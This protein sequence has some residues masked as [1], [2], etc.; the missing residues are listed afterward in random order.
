MLPERHFP[1]LRIIGR[2]QRA[3][4][5]QR[6][7][8]LQCKSHTFSST[9]QVTFSTRHIIIINRQFVVSQISTF[10]DDEVQDSNC[11]RRFCFVGFFLCQCL[12]YQRYILITFHQLKVIECTQ[13]ANFMLII[14][15]TF[16]IIG[17][18]V[19]IFP[20]IER[21]SDTV[22]KIEVSIMNS[23]VVSTEYVIDRIIG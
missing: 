9:L 8:R 22:L 10:T 18:T 12:R 15:V 7:T 11:I 20:F 6:C 1:F 14:Q 5:I 19:G 23:V 3:G 2:I 13:K 21:Q 17:K 16:I 4:K